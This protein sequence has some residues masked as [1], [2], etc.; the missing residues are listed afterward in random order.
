MLRNRILLCGLAGR[1][2]FGTTG[3]T[4]DDVAGSIR[5]LSGSLLGFVDDLLQWRKLLIAR[6][7][8]PGLEQDAEKRLLPGGQPG[9]IG[10]VTDP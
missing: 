3:R 7:A 10:Q 5:C 1:L 2:R 6:P 8:D 9:R 4:E